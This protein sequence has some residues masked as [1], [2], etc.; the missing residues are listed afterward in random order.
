M[1]N[2]GIEIVETQPIQHVKHC[3]IGLPDVGLVGLITVNHVVQAQGMEEV[4]YLESSLL[5]P[6]IVIH[7]GRPKAPIRIFNKGDMAVI[8]SEIPIPTSAI[9]SLS[10]SIIDWAK[11]KD[12]ELLINISGI[13]VPNR[14]EIKVPEVYGVAS[15]EPSRNLLS[16]VDVKLLEEGFMVGP[17]AMILKEAVKKDLNTI[18]V[19]A[20]SH[21]QYPDPGAAAAT[22]NVLN[23]LAGLNVD[24]KKLLEQAEEIRLKMR[25][26]M[27]RTYRSM[28]KM[29]KAQEQELPPMYV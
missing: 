22:V 26:L 25:E 29:Q 4:G 18:V 3:L 27:Q 6:V 12:V 28:Q 13:A 17:Q 24:V 21:Y 5:P 20:Q 23:K 10:T 8:T 11:E 19:M 2:G 15:N 14:L 9:P 7:Q 16:K 1:E